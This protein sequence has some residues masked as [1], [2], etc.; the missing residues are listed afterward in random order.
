MTS[1]YRWYGEF[2][3]GR[4]L[5]QDEFNDGRPK[6]VVVPET[7]DAVR[8]F[9]RA[10]KNHFIVNNLTHYHFYIYVKLYKF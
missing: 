2:N 4:S 7:I 6:S 3:W 8:A 10:F 1:V 5:L 9:K